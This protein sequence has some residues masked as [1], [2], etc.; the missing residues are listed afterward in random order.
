MD[1]PECDFSSFGPG[2]CVVVLVGG[3]SAYVLVGVLSLFLL[4]VRAMLHGV[5]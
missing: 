5:C 3:P 4:L 2:A 1:V